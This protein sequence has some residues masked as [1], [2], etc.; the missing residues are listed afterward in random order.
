MRQQKSLKLQNGIDGGVSVL[1]CQRVTKGETCDQSGVP[2][3]YIMTP[4]QS[5]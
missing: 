5:E 4:D 2:T 1:G 3:H